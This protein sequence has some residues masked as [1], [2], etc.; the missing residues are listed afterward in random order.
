MSRGKLEIQ[1]PVF[2]RAGMDKFTGKI[3]PVYPL[4]SGLTQKVVQSAMQQAITDFGR[5]DE[6]IPDKISDKYKIA[7]KPF[8]SGLTAVLS[9]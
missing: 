3:I 2:E 8:C 4:T 1:N 6:Y 9:F 7:A 5:M